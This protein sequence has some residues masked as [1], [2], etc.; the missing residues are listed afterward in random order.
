M[1]ISARNIINA[2]YGGCRRFP[3]SVC[4]LVIMVFSAICCN[5]YPTLLQDGFYFF[6]IFYPATTALLCI[7]LKLWQEEENDLRRRVILQA[8][9]HVV[10]LVACLYF[11]VRCLL[12]P[13][14]LFLSQLRP[15]CFLSCSRAGCYHSI[16]HP[17]THNC[18]ISC[19]TLRFRLLCVRA[20]HWR[21]L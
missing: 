10:W 2:C 11:R 7:S 12:M 18:G 16:R 9:V 4:M 15:L 13:T 20:L 17:T 14:C 21:S 19:G 8:V 6:L 1:G 5:H 3:A